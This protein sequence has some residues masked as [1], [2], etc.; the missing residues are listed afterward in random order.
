MPSRLQ[1]SE[2]CPRQKTL[3]RRASIQA[4]ERC[5]AQKTETS[6]INNLF[7]PTTYRT[8]WK[9]QAGPTHKRLSSCLHGKT[10]Q[11]SGNVTRRANRATSNAEPRRKEQVDRIRTYNHSAS[12]K[13]TERTV[14]HQ[15]RSL[16]TVG[17]SQH[18]AFENIHFDCNGLSST[19][20][21]N[22]WTDMGS[23]K[24]GSQLDRLSR[25]P[26][27]DQQEAAN[28]RSYR[29]RIFRGTKG[30]E[31]V[32]SNALC[33]RIYGQTDCRHQKIIQESLCQNGSSRRLAAHTETFS[34]FMAGNGWAFS[35]SNLRYDRDNSRNN[36]ESVP[37]IF[38]G[39]SGSIS[40]K[41]GAKTGFRK[42][43][44]KTLEIHVENSV[45]KMAKPL[46]FPRGFDGGA[47]EDRTPDL[48]A[49]SEALSQLSYGPNLSA[50]KQLMRRKI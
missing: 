28:S 34:D 33:G 37:E 49:A 19:Q 12:Q 11:R 41:S 3:N 42:P 48:F 16:R 22:P 46:G 10:S 9:S 8:L 32:R 40:Q 45:P 39:L 25:S 24:L 31:A 17:N 27:D 18:N 4:N 2:K 47:K 6:I 30:S 1:S 5:S 38:A 7:S 13:C 21:R 14:H 29:S 26:I 50:A 15:G 23:C 44:C 36:H 43:V 35:G 20:K